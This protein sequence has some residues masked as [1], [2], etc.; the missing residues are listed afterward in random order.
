LK[1]IPAFAIAAGKGKGKGKCIYIA[2][3]L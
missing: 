3:F 1:I 2:R